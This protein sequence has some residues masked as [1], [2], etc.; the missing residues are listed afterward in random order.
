MVREEEF[1]LGPEAEGGDTPFKA[2]WKDF[3][4]GIK[5][6]SIW[7]MLAWQDI[8]QRYRRS[9][10]GPFWLTI[11]TGIMVG[12]LGFL[13]S[14][15]FQQEIK[16]YLPFLAVGLIVWGFLSTVL[17]EACAVFV[18]SEGMMKQVR[19]PLTVYVCRMVWRNLIIFAH[20]IVI[21]IVVMVWAD[22]SLTWELSLLP[23]AAFLY[24]LNALSIGLLLGIVCTRFRDIGP[25][26]GN[27]AQILFFIT[28]IM[29]SPQILTGKNASLAWIANYNPAY[30]FIEIIRAPLLGQAI[31]IDSWFVVFVSTAILW[32]LMLFVMTK[33]RH[34]LPYWL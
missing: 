5:L 28:P 16:S 29:W 19:L 8:R 24:C 9:V 3:F 31:P 30:H 12:A 33:F 7:S 23:L 4:G 1:H 15:L 20:S 22:V 32:V 18:S 2:A 21:I 17:N 26:I 13:Y 6:Y 11:S 25:F 10:I 27:L 14:G 34:R